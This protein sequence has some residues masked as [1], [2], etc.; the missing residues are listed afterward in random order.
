[1]ALPFWLRRACVRTGLARFLPQAKR[2]TGGEP[3]FAKYVSDRVLAAPLD[4]LL[5]PATFPQSSG[6]D[7]LNLDLGAPDLDS[8]PTL[9]APR[10]MA[11]D[12]FGTAE[13]REAIADSMRRDGRSVDPDRQILIAHGVTGAYAAVLD[14]F[15]NPGDRVALFDPCSPVLHLG[16]KSRRARLR[17]VPTWSEDGRT[18][19][20]NAGL[21]KALSGAKLLVLSQPADPTGGRFSS[22]DSEEIAW[23]ANRHDVL[24]CVDESTGRFHYDGA[25]PVLGTLPGMESR[26]IS[27]DSTTG[28]HGLGSLNVGWLTGHRQLVRAAALC[29]NLNAPGV[30]TVCQRAAAT[31]LRRDRVGFEPVLKASKERR[32]YAFDRLK[33]MGLEPSWP[34]GGVTMWVSV[35][36]CGVGGRSFAERLLREERVLVGPGC[37]YGPSGANFIRVSFAVEEGRLREGLTRMG[38]FVEGLKNPEPKVVAARIPTTSAAL[39]PSFSRV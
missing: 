34:A 33:A 9:R 30:S 29:A 16:A 27:I 32:R 2:L 12:G 8:G 14:A 36:S 7:V 1:L 6:P 5:D 18:R 10:E 23:L 26:T 24:V 19:F 39:E 37:A 13:L 21:S 35:A 38:R 25:A 28:G 17:W 15:V 20:L 3:Q 11:D 22:A 31:V 4:E